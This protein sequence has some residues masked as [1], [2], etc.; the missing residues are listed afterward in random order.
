MRCNSSRPRTS[1]EDLSAP[2]GRG[3]SATAP[4][5]PVSVAITCLGIAVASGP[6]ASVQGRYLM[7][8][9]RI[10]TFGRSKSYHF[11]VSIMSWSAFF[12]A[13]A[14]PETCSAPSCVSFCAT[15]WILSTGYALLS[16]VLNLRLARFCRQTHCLAQLLQPVL[17]NGVYI[18]MNLRG[19]RALP[20][21]VLLTVLLLALLGITA[22]FLDRVRQTSHFPRRDTPQRAQSSPSRS[23]KASKATGVG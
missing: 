11:F 22:L 15:T 14:T 13:H 7:R 4:T 5:W 8:R 16:T 20:Y 10:S 23:N 18:T 6:T 3:K 9:M 1:S 19:N 17:S 12:F 21:H 2:T